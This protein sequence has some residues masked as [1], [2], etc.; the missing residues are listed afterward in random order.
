M[1]RVLAVATHMVSG[2][3]LTSSTHGSLVLV[4]M[5][6]SSY[7]T[8]RYGDESQGGTPGLYDQPRSWFFISVAAK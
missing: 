1:A 6:R 5:P 3:A 2:H 4:F 7:G 8:G